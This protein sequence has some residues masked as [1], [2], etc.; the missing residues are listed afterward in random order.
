MNQIQSLLEQALGALELPEGLTEEQIDD[1]IAQVSEEWMRSVSSDL[2]EDLMVRADEMLAEDR[3]DISAFERRNRRRWKKPVDL[4]R[5]MVRIVQE[6]ISTSFIE[7]DIGEHD[8]YSFD[9][10]NRLCVRSLMVA[11]EVICLV[12]GGFA[13][14]A[15]GRWRSLHEM[16][17]SAAFIAH[18]GESTAERFV[19]AFSF[20]SK[21][22]ML[23]L[24]NY[25]AR[26]NLEPF[27]A[28]E[29][30]A[31]TDL[32][33]N[34][35]ARLGKGL[36]DDYGWAR[37]AL[38]FELNRKPHLLHLEEDTGLDHWR[39]RY[40]WASQNVHSNYA[41]PMASLG[42]AESNAEVHLVGQSN[43]G[44][45]DPLQMSAVS[46]L[47]AATAF[48]GRFPNADRIVIG[49][50]LQQIS[51]QVGDV[52]LTAEAESAARAAT[53]RR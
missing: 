30:Q 7:G 35:E 26:A 3:R 6:T 22:A 48:L 33:E 31:A 37:M 40:R 28:A 11:R 19:A 49:R 34:I 47:I 2:Y 12:E 15:L 27:S 25:A 43:S 45:V 44:M 18:H 17:V 16:A 13:D 24:N 23:Q 42:M 51:D 8:R 9:A 10:L 5:V 1:L 14:G 46:L 4:L 52:A 20:A 36:G 21:K 53:R 41:P 50:V 32:C 29:L 39:P 38:G